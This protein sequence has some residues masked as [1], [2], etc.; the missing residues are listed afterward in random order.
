M[1][2]RIAAAN[3]KLKRACDPPAA[4]DGTRILI[5]RVWPRGVNER[6]YRSVGQENRAQGL[7]KLF[8]RKA[9]RHRQRAALVGF[10][11][12]LL[13][14]HD[15]ARDEMIVRYEAPARSRLA[16]IVQLVDVR[17]HGV[18]YPVSLSGVAACDLEIVV[19][20]VLRQLLGR[21]PFSQEFATAE[22]DCTRA[23]IPIA[24][25]SRPA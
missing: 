19:R 18:A 16:S 4:S 7:A 12:Y 2:K 24:K 25:S 23:L 1:S 20:I 11:G 6:S 10:Q 13:G 8:G 14:Q 3:V 22:L 17:S 15:V 5:D 21:Q 9:I